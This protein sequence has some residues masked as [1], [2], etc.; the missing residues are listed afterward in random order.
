MECQD[1]QAM[2]I[3][4]KHCSQHCR[5]QQRLAAKNPTKVMP[6]LQP[7]QYIPLPKYTNN[8]SGPTN[9][10]RI[11]TLVI[12]TVTSE[13]ARKVQ[14]E[15]DRT[16]RE[17]S[18]KTQI[19]KQKADILAFKKDENL[20]GPASRLKFQKMLGKSEGGHLPDFFR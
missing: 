7:P 20:I 19:K 12:Q 15:G 1:T 2:Q 13:Q 6:R 3:D 17:S 11:K 10:G 5:L 18:E 16:R 4:I 9:T 14:E 8:S